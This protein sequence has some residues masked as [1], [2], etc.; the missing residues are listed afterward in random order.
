MTVNEAFRG[1]NLFSRLSKVYGLLT[2]QDL[3][4]RVQSK[5]EHSPADSSAE[6]RYGTYGTCA[7]NCRD[8]ERSERGLVMNQRETDTS[9]QVLKFAPKEKAP[10]RVAQLDDAG[11]A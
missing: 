3:L 11:Q 10:N 7:S 2:L 1:S 5:V 8:P 4:D 6:V 9:E